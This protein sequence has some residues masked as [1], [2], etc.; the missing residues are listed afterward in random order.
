MTPIASVAA[1]V[2]NVA[3]VVPPVVDTARYAT[4]AGRRRPAGRRL[5]G[6]GVAGPHR[7]DARTAGDPAQGRAGDGPAGLRQE[8]G[9]A[10]SA[11]AAGGVDRPG[12]G[13][14]EREGLHRPVLR[15]D[16]VGSEQGAG[17][18]RPPARPAHA[19]HA[20][21]LPHGV[22]VPAQRARGRRVLRL[23]AHRAR[24]RHRQPR[25][26]GRAV[27]PPGGRRGHRQLRR[28]RQR[29]GRPQ[30]GELPARLRPD[31]GRDDRR[32][33]RHVTGH[34]PAARLPQGDG[35]RRRSTIRG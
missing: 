11:A 7:L 18:G 34:R 17:L 30:G 27:R 12:S 22:A 4:H 26:T 1:S 28:R 33:A 6:H 15:P 25:H 31:G 32:P 9:R 16:P 3:S 2:T 8:P 20:T 24:L 13:R 5:G 29:R 21:R 14:G 35:R 23:H 10:H 19:A